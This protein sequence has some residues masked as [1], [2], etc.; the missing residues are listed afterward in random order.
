MDKGSRQEGSSASGGRSEGNKRKR[1]CFDCVILFQ[2]QKASDE[3]TSL[4]E[5]PVLI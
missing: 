5:D 1:A 2:A 3:Y 4:I